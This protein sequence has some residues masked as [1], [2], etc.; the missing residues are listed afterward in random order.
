MGVFKVDDRTVAEMYAAGRNCRAIGRQIGVSAET[1]RRALR[2]QGIAIRD[3]RRVPVDDKQTRVLYEGGAT[4]DEIAARLGL[5]RYVVR[6]ALA[7]SGITPRTSADYRRTPA[8]ADEVV[9]LY[10]ET[11][12]SKKVSNRLGLPESTVLRILHERGVRTRKRA[13]LLSA[14][15][16]AEA[17]RLYR[18][19]APVRGIAERISA[20]IRSI[21]AAFAEAGITPKDRGSA[22]GPSRVVTGKDGA[23]IA[24]RVEDDD[25]LA[26]MRTAHGYVLEHR[27]A[28]ARQL[29]RPLLP[30]ETVH[31]INNDGHDNRPENLQLRFGRHGTGYV[32]R[33]A[34]CGSHRL[35]P[36]KLA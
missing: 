28:M 32:M 33:C 15:Q 7:R 1:V 34:D 13:Y 22:L 25:P 18:E 12:S 16:F 21:Q 2:R 10:G 6:G 14:G 31:H 29:G 17:E 19:G 36:T 20:P 26:C 24:V 5:T 30:G 11:R 4:Y 9:R 3:G 35:E 27:L 23:Y 8:D